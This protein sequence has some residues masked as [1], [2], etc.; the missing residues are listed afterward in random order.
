MFE[1]EVDP[2]TRYAPLAMQ[3]DREL[4]KKFREEGILHPIVAKAI[5]KKEFY[6]QVSKGG[7][8]GEISYE[9][10]ALISIN[11]KKVVAEESGYCYKPPP[12]KSTAVADMAAEI[13]AAANKPKPSIPV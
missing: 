8:R 5:A 7:A 9:G 12:R 11:G 1:V 10:K 6:E 2:W 13:E 3:R 4:A